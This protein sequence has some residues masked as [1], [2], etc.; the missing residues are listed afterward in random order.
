MGIHSTPPISWRRIM[1]Q[2]HHT[3]YDPLLSR[4]E[5][6]EYLGVNER[7]LANW[8]CTKRYPLPTVKVGRLVKYRLSA[9]DKFIAG[10]T[11]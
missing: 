1:T 9:L 3:K 5:A 2:K 7:T 6:A 8:K 10:G 11:E 4:K